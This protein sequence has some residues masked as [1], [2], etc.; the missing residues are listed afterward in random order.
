MQTVYD[1]QN[2][3]IY[4]VRALLFLIQDK[5]HCDYHGRIGDGLSG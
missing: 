2:Y 5:V 4:K 1:V 3:I